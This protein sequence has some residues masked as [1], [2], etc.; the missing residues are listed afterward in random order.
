MVI[1]GTMFS[2]LDPILSIAACLSFK[3]PFCPPVDQNE[4][5]AAKEKKV[6]LSMGQ[7]SDHV[8]LALAVRKYE[9]AAKNGNSYVKDLCKEFFLS[10]QTLKLIVDYKQQ[11]ATALHDIQFLETDEFWDPSLNAYSTNLELVKAVA[12]M[13]LFPN[14]AV[15]T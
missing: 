1:L 5:K 4:Q 10:E 6:M 15:N 7:Y 14:V 13:G 9:E 3:P 12:C 11:F 2:C 8:A